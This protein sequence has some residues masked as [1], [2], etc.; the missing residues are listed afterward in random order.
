MCRPHGPRFACIRKEKLT[1]LIVCWGPPIVSVDA[2][3]PSP[4][5]KPRASLKDSSCSNRL[6]LNECETSSLG[7]NHIDLA[8]RHR[9]LF[10]RSPRLGSQS[11]HLVHDDI[12]HDVIIHTEVAVYQTISHPS[13]CSPIDVGITRR[14][15]SRR[16]RNRFP[17]NIEAALD[18]KSQ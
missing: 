9:P 5:I 13:R 2:M 12:P 17:N 3:R 14:D 11:R 16:L 4:S 15:P 18:A 7:Q 10:A 8:D 6:Q 1:L